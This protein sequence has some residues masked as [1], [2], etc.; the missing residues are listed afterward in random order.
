MYTVWCAL[1]T[2]DN[3]GNSPLVIPTCCVQNTHDL[4][5]DIPTLPRNGKSIKIRKLRLLVRNGHSRK[6]IHSKRLQD[7]QFQNGTT[8]ESCVASQTLKQLE[9]FAVF[10]T[11]NIAITE[12]KS[13]EI[14]PSRYVVRK[15]KKV[16]S[17][18]D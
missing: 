6:C 16:H 5:L 13:S 11:K 17:I 10:T 1:C 4:T 8:A 12:T 15:T 18:L 9:I 2:E 3:S 14:I 7:N